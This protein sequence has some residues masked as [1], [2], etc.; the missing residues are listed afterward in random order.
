MPE[1]GAG[2]AQQRIERD[3][4]SADFDSGV[5]AGLWQQAVLR[6]PHLTAVVTAGD[7]R[8]LGL[9]IAVDDYPALAPGGRLWDLDRDVPLPPAR[10]PA[11]G[12]A[13]Q[14]F[15]PDWPNSTSPAPYIACDREG[16]AAHPNWADE[17]P[18]RAWNPR[19]TIAFYLRQIHHELRAAKLPQDQARS[20]G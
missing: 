1:P 3:L 10:W 13:A 2:P 19:R 11:G 16:L 17:H 7:G 4:H 18:G 5:R 6:W 14:V 8:Q 9:R 20:A 15:R 12:S